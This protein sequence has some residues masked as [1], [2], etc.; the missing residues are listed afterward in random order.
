MTWVVGCVC[1]R[2][3]CAWWDAWAWLAR[4]TSGSFFP[5][6]GQSKHH[7]KQQPPQNGSILSFFW[8]N[9][10]V[11]DKPI[12]KCTQLHLYPGKWLREAD[13]FCPPSFLKN[14]EICS[15]GRQ[16]LKKTATTLF[17]LQIFYLRSKL[18]LKTLAKWAI[19]VGTGAW[20]SS[21]RLLVNTSTISKVMDMA[22]AG[23]GTREAHLHRRPWFTSLLV[24]PCSQCPHPS[25]SPL[26]STGLHFGHLH[27]F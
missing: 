16:F 24:T 3:E 25:P 23:W 26:A 14:I 12:W 6:H 21:W 20:D 10:G 4:V 8:Q 27:P 5:R 9:L 2:C 18:P 11:A 15:H 22:W 17:W 1:S 19:N 7:Y 13:D